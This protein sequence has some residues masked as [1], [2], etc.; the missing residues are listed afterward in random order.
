MGEQGITDCR[1]VPWG[2]EHEGLGGT[3]LDWGSTA[4]RGLVIEDGASESD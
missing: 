3:S 1:E 2:G 4:P